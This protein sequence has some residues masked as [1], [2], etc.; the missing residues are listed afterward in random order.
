MAF[1]SNNFVTDSGANTNAPR[2]NRYKE[3]VT[4]ATL[5]GAGYFDAAVSGTSGG[6]YGLRD[7][8]LILVAGSDGTSFLSM[9]VSGSNVAT[10]DSANDFA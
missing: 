6:G 5:K 10:V 1:T 3:A 2:I 9:A 8:D 4:L 7:G